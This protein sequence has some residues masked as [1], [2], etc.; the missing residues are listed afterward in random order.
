MSKSLNIHSRHQTTDVSA[1]P[2]KTK[3]EILHSITPT[4]YN[5]TMSRAMRK[6]IPLFTVN[7]LRTTQHTL[8]QVLRYISIADSISKDTLRELHRKMA[9]QTFMPTNKITEDFNNISRSIMFPR[10]TWDLFEKAILIMGYDVTDVQ[11]Q[12]VNRET[13]ECIKIS[14]SDVA[15]LVTDNPVAPIVVPY[16]SRGE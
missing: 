10:V 8:A 16:P 3:E 6:G 13:G 9:T 7:D 11:F 12:L 14:K 5:Q 2:I 1:V 15:K 4:E